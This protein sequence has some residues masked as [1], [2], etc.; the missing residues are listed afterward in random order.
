[1]DTV[2]QC[3]SF[4]SHI[5]M[6]LTFFLLPYDIHNM[7]ILAIKFNICESL[8]NLFISALLKTGKYGLLSPVHSRMAFFFKD[9]SKIITQVFTTI[10]YN[11]PY[12][13]LLASE[14]CIQ[15]KLAESHAIL[16][17]LVEKSQ[18]HWNF[19]YSLGSAKCWLWYRC[20]LFSGE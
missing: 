13:T 20:F 12:L 7:E 4:I 2:G 9:C 15:S 16:V 5:A 6:V 1:M 3:S 8:H 17:E 19:F 18:L 10:I 11:Y 14:L